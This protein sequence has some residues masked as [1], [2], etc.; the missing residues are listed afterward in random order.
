MP[1]ELKSKSENMITLVFKRIPKLAIKFSSSYSLVNAV[2][3]AGLAQASYSK[4][5]SE[6]PIHAPRLTFT[7][8]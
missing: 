3:L 5:K 6:N 4:S 1:F 2:N 8:A 7:F